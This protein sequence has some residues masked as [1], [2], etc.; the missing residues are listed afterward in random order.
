MGAN[1]FFAS[2]GAVLEV[3]GWN[4][5]D[6]LLSAWR[7]RVERAGDR[8]GWT[9]RQSVVRRHSGGASLAIAAPRDLLFLATEVNEWA[10][11]AALAE[12]DPTR[13]SDLQEA[14][15]AAALAASGGTENAAAEPAPV[16]AE[17]AAL[18]RFELLAREEAHPRLRALLEEAAS[19]GLPH[20]LDESE[21]TLGAGAGGLSFPLTALPSGSDLRWAELHDIPTAIVTGSNGKT[22]TVRLLAACATAHGWRVGYNCTDGVFVE[23]DVLANGDYSGPAGTRMVMREHRVQAAILESA[24]GGILRRGIAVSRADVAV[25]TNISADHFGEYGIHDI[26]GLAHVKLAVAAVVAPGGLLVLN[27]DDP[28]LRAQAGA[29][30]GRF[31]RSPPLGWFALD[32]DHP[33]LCEGRA[34]GAAT[35]GMRAGRLQLSHRGAEHDLGPASGMPLSIGGVATYNMANLAGAALA[36]SALGVAAATIAAVFARFGAN[37]H[38]NPGRMMRFE[39]NGALILLDYAHN[40]DGLRGLLT[41]AA[42]LRAANGRLGLLLGQAGNRQDADL[43][44]LARVAAEFGPDLVVVKEN[45]TQLRGRAPGEVPRIIRAELARLGLPE[46]ALP[47]RNSEIEAA[48]YALDWARPGDVLAMPVHSPNARAAVTAL[49]LESSPPATTAWRHP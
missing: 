1:I 48:R 19:R 44:Q 28:Q 20:V 35:C 49:L 37:L 29:L 15:A 21:L 42:H 16:I 22:T 24:R 39:F 46:S 12:R 23:D 6:A 9:D 25:V 2:P 4:P 14:L 11:C 3:V 10:L 8:L 47:V 45:E 38:D 43:E 18:A 13:W 5:D 27:A 17:S 32:A 31:G 34:R 41:V 30:H 26:E 33:T 36:A 7:A 40:P